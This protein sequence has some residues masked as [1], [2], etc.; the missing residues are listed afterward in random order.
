MCSVGWGHVFSFWANVFSFWPD[1]FTFRANV[2]TLAGEVFSEEGERDWEG[3]RG[4]G[5][6]VRPEGDGEGTRGSGSA[7][8]GQG[9]WGRRSAGDVSTLSGQCVQFLGLMCQLF[10]RMCPLW[11]G[12]CHLG[13]AEGR[14]ERSEIG[15][16]GEVRLGLVRG[17]GVVR[18]AHHE[19]GCAGIDHGAG[20]PPRIRV[21]GRLFAGMTGV[22]GR[23]GAVSTGR[24]RCVQRGRLRSGRRVCRHRE[25]APRCENRSLAQ[26]AAACG[27]CCITRSWV[28]GGPLTD[29]G[30]RRPNPS[31]SSG[32]VLP[33]P[34]ER[35]KSGGR[36]GGCSRVGLVPGRPLTTFRRRRRRLPLPQERDL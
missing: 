34:L 36:G 4:E 15:G 18:R 30:R 16:E 3:Q 21:R 2:F 23:M 32:Q 10:G 25:G 31:A 22:A 19:R 33:L 27:G 9:L 8:S 20:S 26:Q 17:R 14:G 12:R 5:R 35:V 24:P 11:R 1:V 28:P 29:F 7:G 13:R 6:E